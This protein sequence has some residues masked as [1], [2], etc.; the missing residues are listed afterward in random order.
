MRHAVAAFALM[1]LVAGCE[2]E[3]IEPQFDNASTF[4]QQQEELLKAELDKIQS[5]I[6]QKMQEHIKTGQEALRGA[7]PR[8]QTNP[9]PNPNRK[10]SILRDSRDTR[11]RN[12][13]S[14]DEWRKG[15]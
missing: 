2:E 4:Q 12:S 9:N 10:Q 14:R 7:Q 5:Q 15:L 3:Q 11:K 8:I 13:E 1:L 6:D